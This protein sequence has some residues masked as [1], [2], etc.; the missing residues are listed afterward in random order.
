M[1]IHTMRSRAGR[2]QAR[3]IAALLL[4][5][6]S[7][8][9]L[10]RIGST[11]G[12]EAASPQRLPGE[13]LDSSFGGV[14]VFNPSPGALFQI[15]SSQPAIVTPQYTQVDVAK[16]FNITYF[17]GYKVVENKKAYPSPQKYVLTQ[18]G[19][20]PPPASQFPQGTIFLSIPLVSVAVEDA[21]A[22]AFMDLL[23]LS[24]RVSYV[25]QFA[26]N[27]CFQAIGFYGCKKLTSGD[28]NNYT[29]VDTTQVDGIFGYQTS[30]E[31]ISVSAAPDPGPLNRAEWI[32]YVA[33]F[34]NVEDKAN[35]I[36]DQISKSYKDTAAAVAAK[37]DPDVSKRPVVA[38]LYWNPAGFGD[39][40]QVQISFATYKANYTQDAGGRM[41][42][43]KAANASAL[44]YGTWGKDTLYQYQSLIL[45]N[46]SIVPQQL[47]EI[48]AD[49]DVLIEETRF[50]KPV[51]RNVDLKI[52][53]VLNL[54]GFNSTDLRTLKF[55]KNNKVVREDARGNPDGYTD[56]F[57]TGLARP[58]IVLKELSAIVTPSA[59]AA[60]ADNAPPRIFR[61]L[62]VQQPV[63][64]QSSQCQLQGCSLV[65]STICPLVYRACNGTVVA[66][67]E[68]Q[69]CAPSSCNAATAPST[70]TAPPPPPLGAG[71]TSPLSAW[72]T[73]LAAALALAL[74]L[75]AVQL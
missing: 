30:N 65:S 53:D 19:M 59:V 56:W 28:A 70:T 3:V 24:G 42:D 27:P 66:A 49:V 43:L 38:W 21:A 17:P 45:R 20:E 68:S 4:A 61:I 57:E 10:Q 47:R 60:P 39:P 67:T 36:F 33:A 13:C 63:F 54:Y 6:S 16:D 37:A 34:F 41:L 75:M 35:A 31:T 48:L 11:N 2:R 51:V 29:N 40:A 14:N 58:D 72:A 55:F 22:L 52:S 26:V 69:R 15:S 5:L 50:T 62:G 8:L 46:F 25:S 74:A 7:A 32:K 23:G 18:C 12:A 1:A 71:V 9:A 44:K 64:L 73:T